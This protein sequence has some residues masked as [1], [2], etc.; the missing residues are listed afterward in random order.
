LEWSG[1]FLCPALLSFHNR[2]HIP[3]HAYQTYAYDPPS[4]LMVAV[5]GTTFL[6]DVARR[7]WQ[8]PPVNTPFLADVMRVSLETTP[9]GVVAWA[10]KEQG[11]DNNGRLW[12]FDGKTR[13]WK[14]LP[15]TGP[16]I[17]GPWCDGSGLCYDA[18][19]NCL[20]LA[21]KRELFRYDF[22]DGTMVKVETKPPKALGQFALWR[23]QVHVPEADLIL[24]MRLWPGPDGQPRQA[25]YDPVANKWYWLT[26]PFVT[27]DGRP[28]AFGK[29]DTPFS[30]NSARCHDRRFG[31]VLLH[32]PV[33]VW[34]LRFHRETAR[35]SEV[36]E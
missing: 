11:R 10:Q 12:I 36:Q 15:Q 27:A 34:A 8:F 20:W 21:P 29:K 35:M 3:V 23:E 18:K 4:G 6:Y 26:L 19:R 28:H 9:M 32:N 5:R 22:A 2:P 7:E 30:W 17:Q 14:L 24:L 13:A 16:G 33:S 1:G 31:V 25:A